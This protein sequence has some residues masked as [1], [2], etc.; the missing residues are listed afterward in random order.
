MGNV[1]K[2]KLHYEEEVCIE[3]I[4]EREGGFRNVRRERRR[5]VAAHDKGEKIVQPI[6]L[7]FA[8]NESTG[9]LEFGGTSSSN[10]KNMQIEEYQGNK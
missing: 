9:A 2:P 3:V 6:K 10:N 1:V 4:T 8:R 5:T 7:S